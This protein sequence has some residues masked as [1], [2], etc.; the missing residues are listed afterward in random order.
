MKKL[1]LAVVPVLLLA[2]PGGA[3]AQRMVYTSGSIV[4]AASNVAGPVAP[5]S[6]VS[7]YGSG[8]S[9]VARALSDEDIR[10]GVLPIALPAT[11]VT[12]TI[13][14]QLARFYY[15]SPTQ[16]NILVPALLIP[17]EYVAKVAR[18]AN[19][20]PEVK[21]TVAA[22]APGLFLLDADTALATRPDGSVISREQPAV[23]GEAVILHATGLGQT[24]PRVSDGE[25]PREAR[26]MEA[27]SE[28]RVLLDGNEI[29][30]SRV[31]YAG[32]APGFAGLYQVNLILP[33]TVNENPE[34]RLKIGEALSPAG[35]RLPVGIQP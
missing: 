6:I 9:Y 3:L 7:I 17:G 10:A 35:P 27:F 28:F 24:V 29:E 32:V 25:I 5:N 20:G 8:L 16:I 30:T 23:P 18:D 12:A 14:R 15:V 4:N 22:T 1:L 19:G 33:E 21:I 2:L 11:G 13:G 31:L 34:I 26:Y